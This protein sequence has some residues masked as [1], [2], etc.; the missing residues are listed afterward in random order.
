MNT[1]VSTIDQY[2][3]GFPAD[4]QKRLKEMRAIIKKSAPKAEEA[5]KYGIPTF[6]QKK[7]LVHFGGYKNHIGF[8]PSPSG[9]TTLAKETARYQ[10]GKGTLQFPHDQPLPADLITR[11]VKQRLKDI[12]AIAKKKSST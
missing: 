9:I 10:A 8:Y 4:V 7:N 6:I 5:I 3:A 1:D 11:I 12:G 2:I